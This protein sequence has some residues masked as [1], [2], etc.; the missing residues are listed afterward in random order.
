MSTT[1][2]PPK[3]P[4]NNTAHEPR[5]F[6]PSEPEDFGPITELGPIDP[7]VIA[8]NTAQAARTSPAD[9][10]PPPHLADQLLEDAANPNIPLLTIAQNAGITLNTLRL[11]LARP[12][13]SEQLDAIESTL[14]RRARLKVLHELDNIT[15]ACATILERFHRAP[16][17]GSTEDRRPDT[18]LRAS[19]IITRN[20]SNALMASRVLLALARYLDGPPRASRP[21]PTPSNPDRNLNPHPNRPPSTSPLPPQ[22]SHFRPLRL[23]PTLASIDLHD[24]RE[25]LTSNHHHNGHTVEELAPQHEV[26]TRNSRGQSEVGRR[27]TSAAHGNETDDSPHPARPARV[28]REPPENSAPLPHNTTTPPRIPAPARGGT[29]PPQPCTCGPTP[30]TN[31]PSASALLTI[32]GTQIPRSRDPTIP[33][34]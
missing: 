10:N 9:F 31:C 7:G 25:Y 20:A 22:T 5:V 34:R 6:R 11:W 30:C 24:F 4:R 28:Q 12:E 16:D 2:P 19:S 15:E 18:E 33:A 27:P 26:L 14:R 29:T 21:A 23:L 1:T 3:P 8:E 17:R 13:I 32:A